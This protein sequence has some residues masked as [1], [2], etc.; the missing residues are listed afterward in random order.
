VMNLTSLVFLAVLVL[1][2][3]LVIAAIVRTH[4]VNW[5][6]VSGTCRRPSSGTSPGGKRPKMI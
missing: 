3:V 2:S 4:W 5:P 6:T 1:I